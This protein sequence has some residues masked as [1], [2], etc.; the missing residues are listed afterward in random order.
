[1]QYFCQRLS[2]LLP[3]IR[4]STLPRLMSPV[5][6]LT[7]SQISTHPQYMPKASLQASMKD[8]SPSPLHQFSNWFETARNDPNIPEPET[9]VLGTA[10]ANGVPSS[11]VV[12]LRAVDEKG[13]VFFTNYGSRKGRE[14]A[15]NDGWVSMNWYWY[16]QNRQVRVVGKAEKVAR[17]ESQAYFDT[18]PI[19]S[20]VGAW[21]S[22][23]SA[24]I[25]SG[26]RDELQKQVELMENKFG[27]KDGE[28][29]IPVPDFWGGYRVVPTE[30]EF[31][32]GQPNRLHD[33]FRYTKLEGKEG[34]KIERLNP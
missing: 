5:S 3:R 26:E 22:R 33:R 25:E 24:V 12:L 9:L 11:R 14:I 10:N 7:L 1:M 21:A 18:R 19:G 16:A 30:V 2:L 31:W 15:E 27:V 20:R 8:L 17:E 6:T 29:K 32:V 23:Q 28:T 34:W 4:T 13:F